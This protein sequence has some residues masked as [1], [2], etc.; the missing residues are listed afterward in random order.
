V[1]HWASSL[2]PSSSRQWCRWRTRACTR[3]RVGET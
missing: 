1:S 2:V 3:E